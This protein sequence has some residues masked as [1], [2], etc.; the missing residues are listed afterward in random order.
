MPTESLFRR[1]GKYRDTASSTPREN[2]LTES[3]ATVLSQVDGLA[4][5]L[6]DEWLKR[7]GEP[8]PPLGDREHQPRIATQRYVPTSTPATDGPEHGFVDL[9]LTYER[10][11]TLPA[12][13]IRVEVKYGSHLHD[14]QVSRYRA[15]GSDVIVLC[16]ETDL[17]LLRGAIPYRDVPLVTWQE[18][19]HRLVRLHADMRNPVDRWLLQQFLDF[20]REENLVV[21]ENLTADHLSALRAGRA[22]DDALDAIRRLAI[23]YVSDRSAAQFSASDSGTWDSRA[24]RRNQYQLFTGIDAGLWSAGAYLEFKTIDE[25]NGVIFQAGVTGPD[26]STRLAAG[27]EGEVRQSEL[28]THATE[29]WDAS[30]DDRSR[31]VRRARPDDLFTAGEPLERQA[32]ALG[33]WLLETFRALTTN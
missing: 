27:P 22:A 14:D 11:G 20:L 12:R 31:L 17:A 15:D 30:P 9:E 2:R 23:D 16:A 19:A 4:T 3:M 25:G 26:R 29:L 5:A 24:T 10:E 33:D 13:T 21:P 6:V 1:L 18:T 32:R 8:P 28:I 7:A